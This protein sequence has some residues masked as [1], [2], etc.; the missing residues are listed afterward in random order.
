MNDELAMSL[1]SQVKMTCKE[2]EWFL[3]KQQAL[4]MKRCCVAGCKRYVRWLCRGGVVSCRI[5]VC[6]SHEN[7]LMKDDEEMVYIENGMSG[8]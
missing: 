1:H 5:G 6:Y 2:H 7:D 8:R 3:V 4:C